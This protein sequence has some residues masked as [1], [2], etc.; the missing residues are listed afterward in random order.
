MPPRSRVRPSSNSAACL[1][2]GAS[3]TERGDERQRRS[4]G[5]RSSR[6][7]QGFVIRLHSFDRLTHIHFPDSSNTCY[8][9]SNTG[10]LTPDGPITVSS[11]KDLDGTI[12]SLSCG[13]Q[14]ARS[15]TTSSTTDGLGR[16]IQSADSAGVV[17]AKTLDALGRVAKQFNPGDSVNG[18]TYTYDALGRVLTA[19]YADGS[20]ETTSYAGDL[21]THMDPAG[22][23]TTQT[24]DGLGR[25]MQVT[26]DTT[27][28]NIATTYTYDALDDFDRGVTQAGPGRLIYAPTGQS[29]C[30]VY[31]S[32]KELVSATNPESGTTTYT[33]DENGNLSMKVSGPVTTTPMGTIRWIGFSCGV[34]RWLR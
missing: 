32:L 29:R 27:G 24:V 12:Q 25:I 13:S 20:Q 31:D 2:G 15:T 17:T 14:A 34:I 3:A 30:F 16:V 1:R 33:Y 19:T 9:Y 6:L 21:S 22:A 4:A 23:S 26:E 18:T 11:T 7:Q 5:T 28:L 10:S 8:A